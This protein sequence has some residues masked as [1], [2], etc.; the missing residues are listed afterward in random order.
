MISWWHPFAH[1]CDLSRHP[2]WP[3]L[4]SLPF[5]PVPYPLQHVACGRH[6]VAGNGGPEPTR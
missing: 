2:K 6:P 4:P 3:R 1:V 5:P